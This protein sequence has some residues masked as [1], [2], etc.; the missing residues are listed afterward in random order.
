MGASIRPE[1]WSV[2]DAGTN[3]SL[4]TYAEYRS[5]NFDSSLIDISQRISWSKQLNSSEGAIYYNN[6]TVFSG[7]DPCTLS[8]L[9]CPG[10]PSDIAVSNFKAKKGTPT[11][12][13]FF[14]W[15]ISWPLV[16]IT[17]EL[18]RSTDK[19]SFAKINEQTA[20][21]D[22]AVNFVYTE[23]LPPAGSIYYYYVRASKDGLASHITDTIQ[24]S[25]TPALLSPAA[26]APLFSSWVPLP[27]HRHT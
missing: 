1:G 6:A 20:L 5:R 27:L 16:G 8:A 10:A 7:W 26:Q 13:T 24:V 9:L 3:T 22:T 15:N 4:I 11:T 2:W 21:S 17:Y 12:P 23:A 25:T 18:F 14:S 19:I